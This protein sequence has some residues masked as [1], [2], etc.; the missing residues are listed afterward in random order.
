FFTHSLTN[1]GLLNE[2]DII[3]CRNVMI[4]CDTN[5]QLQLLHLFHKSMHEKSFLII[6]KDEKIISKEGNQLFSR[7]EKHDSVLQP[8]YH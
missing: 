4:Y 8:I 3:F 2:F 7:Y 5:L 1:V 6:G